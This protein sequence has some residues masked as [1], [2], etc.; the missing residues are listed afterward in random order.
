[1]RPQPSTTTSACASTPGSVIGLTSLVKELPWSSLTRHSASSP[2]TG[3]RRSYSA[4]APRTGGADD[5]TAAAPCLV[6]LRQPPAAG[7]ARPAAIGRAHVRTCARPPSPRRRAPSPWVAPPAHGACGSAPIPTPP[8][9]TP[10]HPTPPQ[11]PRAGP[12]PRGTAAEFRPHLD[13]R[14]LPRQKAR[15]PSPYQ[16]ARAPQALPSRPSKSTRIRIMRSKS[17]RSRTRWPA[18]RERCHTAG[19]ERARPTHPPCW[20]AGRRPSP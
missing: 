5:D 8:Y 13:R 16:K 9:P 15:A 20:A 14:A 7:R 2:R 6:G 18:E 3:R 12:A 10:P 19:P 11:P 1:M 17:T 4:V